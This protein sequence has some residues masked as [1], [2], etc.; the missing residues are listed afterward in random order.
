M[1]SEDSNIYQQIV[2][3]ELQELEDELA[4]VQNRL[5]N[6][7]EVLDEMWMYHPANPDFINPIKAYDILK[8][9]I[10]DLEVRLADLELKIK[11]LKSTN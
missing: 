7:Y 10:V 4:N 5:I 11:A 9:S 8:K 1:S 2:D 6:D 3:M